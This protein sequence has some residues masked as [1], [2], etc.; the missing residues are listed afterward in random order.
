II[1][2]RFSPINKSGDDPALEEL[3]K[4]LPDYVKG[5]KN[6]ICVADGSGSMFT[7]IGKTSVTALA[8]ANSL[9]IYFAERSGGVFKN[10]YITFSE[11]PQLGDFSKCRSLREKIEVALAHN[12]C[13]NTNIEKVF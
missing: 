11:N 1:C 12:E 10:K 9:A 3:W 4:A 7:H 6:T 8:V 5:D 13:S 2:S